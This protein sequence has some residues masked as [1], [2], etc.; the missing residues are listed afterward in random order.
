MVEGRRPCGGAVLVG[1]FLRAR[2]CDY[3]RC[4]TG[5]RHEALPQSLAD[6]PA[7]PALGKYLLLTAAFG[8]YYLYL[9]A[10][11]RSCRRETG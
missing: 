1:R 9:Y 10:G 3:F 2:S 6:V 11:L 8:S 4:F 7:L 5:A